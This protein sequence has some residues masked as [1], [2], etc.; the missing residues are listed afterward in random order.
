[1]TAQCP[2]TS[3]VLW[4][5]ECDSKHQSTVKDVS[6]GQEII[7]KYFSIKYEFHLNS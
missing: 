1:M 3:D 2:G 5:R 7:K 4:L 6:G